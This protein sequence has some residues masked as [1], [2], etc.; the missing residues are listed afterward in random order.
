[1]QKDIRHVQTN[2]LEPPYQ[3]FKSYNPQACEK[4]SWS[5]NDTDEVVKFPIEVPD[6]SKLKINYLP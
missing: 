2:I 6:G 4:S 3:Y 1:M 5:A